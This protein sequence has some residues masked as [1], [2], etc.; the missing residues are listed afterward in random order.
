VAL[1]LVLALLAGCSGGSG[2]GS[3]RTT[4]TPAPG[5][6]RSEASGPGRPLVA[7]MR[8]ILARAAAEGRDELEIARIAAYAGLSGAQAVTLAAPRAMDFTALSD[9]PLPTEVPTGRIDGTTAAVEAMVTAARSLLDDPASR[10]DVANLGTRLAE[11]RALRVA[12]REVTERSAAWG[13]HVGENTAAWAATDGIGDLRRQPAWQPPDTPGAWQPTPPARRPPLRPTWG[14]LR[15]FVRDVEA[16]GVTEP[17]PF[18]TRSGLPYADELRRVFLTARSRE[19]ADE[20]TA[21]R[22]DDSR[23]G[24]SGPAGHWLAIA[25]RLAVQRRLDADRTARL[26]A[27]TATAIGDAYLMT[28]RLKYAYARARPIAVIRD[29]GWDRRWLPYLITPPTPEYPS[30]RAMVA[31]AAA[32][33]LAHH[34]GD[35]TRFTDPGLPNGSSRSGGVRPRTYPGFGAAAREATRSRLLGGVNLAHSLEASYR[36]GRCLALQTGGRLD[37]VRDAIRDPEALFPAPRPSASR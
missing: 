4:T 10:A 18:E 7:V 23:A 22:W 6:D 8:A 2:S 27:V 19:P 17:L 13:R 14:V 9:Y 36:L 21:R 33:V 30:A 32:T 12:D 20:A 15:L 31:G 16:C 35:R 29:L 34:F 25:G 11:A 26:L 1:T 28:W 37:G 5:A 3:A 24:S